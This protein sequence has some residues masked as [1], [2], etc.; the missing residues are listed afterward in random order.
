M[1]GMKA[2]KGEAQLPLAFL[3]LPLRR[4]RHRNY[5]QQFRA[6]PDSSIMRQKSEW[7]A[8]RARAAPP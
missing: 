7:A 4:K 3:R 8:P 5:L 2:P 1:N 6:D